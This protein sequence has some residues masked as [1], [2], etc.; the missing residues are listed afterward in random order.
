MVLGTTLYTK[1]IL[2]K[3]VYSKLL[4]DTEE[5]ESFDTKQTQFNS[6]IIRLLSEFSVYK[7]DT[8]LILRELSKTIK[9][10]LNIII[11]KKPKV[12]KAEPSQTQKMS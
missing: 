8:N 11:N 6:G 3:Y 7:L 10:Y 4:G 5:D 12:A 2:I 1:L 9:N